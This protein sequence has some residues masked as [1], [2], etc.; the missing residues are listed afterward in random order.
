MAAEEKEIKSI[1]SVI[2]KNKEEFVSFNMRFRCD[3]CIAKGHSAA[4]DDGNMEEE[5]EQEEQQ[6]QREEVEVV[7]EDCTC[8]KIQ[9]VTFKVR[10]SLIIFHLIKMRKHS[11]ACI[12]FRTRCAFSA[13]RSGNWLPI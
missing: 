3:A 9:K 13:P 1:D 7:D 2:A 10:L 8:I 12:L 4:N 6:Q 11:N 5:E